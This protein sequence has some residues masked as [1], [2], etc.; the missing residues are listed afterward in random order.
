MIISRC[1]IK[2][3]FPLF[4]STSTF[5][6]SFQNIC[7]LCIS[8]PS[9]CTAMAVNNTKLLP[10]DQQNLPSHRSLLFVA[11]LKASFP[12]SIVTIL[13]FGGFWSS[14]RWCKSKTELPKERSFHIHVYKI[15]MHQSKNTTRRCK[16][17]KTEG[18][19]K[20]RIG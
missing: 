20:E 19:I 5:F 11:R 18:K 7:V 13:P 16:F 14:L 6:T 8:N 3:S 2:Q 15:G 17:R 4:G 12:Q 10:I 9:V 1:I